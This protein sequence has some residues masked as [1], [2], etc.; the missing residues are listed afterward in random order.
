MRAKMTDLQRLSLDIYQG[1]NVV[2]NDVTGEQA[3]RNMITEAV[4]G[5]FNYK[6]FREN[7]YRVF[8]IIEEALDA[9]L[10]VV[11][12]NQFDSLAD[13][14]NVNAGD[15][16]SFRVEDNN[17]F[18]VARIAGGTNDLRRQKILN[19]HVTVDTDWYGVKIYE[20]LEM[21]IA[22]R[23]D[24]A[25]MVNR[26]ALSFSHFMGTKIYEA[27][28]NSYSALNS[29]RAVTG[30]YNEDALLDIVEHVEAKSGQKAS[31]FGTKKALRAISKGI[32]LS[33]SGKDQLNQ[34]GYVGTLAGTDLILLPQAHK[35]G[36]EEFFVDDK[37]LIIV[38][39]NEKIV[40][41]VIEG[42][43]LMIESADAGDRNDQQMEY[44]LQKKF[45][46]GVLQSSV[47]GIYKM[48]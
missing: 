47:Y 30:T 18:R 3:L 36:T 26:V 19:K 11:L 5:E 25:S 14:R 4:G 8:A 28:A 44:I 39:A 10:G 23:V 31:I 20:E 9:V 21:F 40:K 37:M 32:D 22:G 6:N 2:F 17:L 43:A 34:M 15:K 33:D 13:V 41:V 16:I 27:I 45:G 7:K 12:T 38:P 1:K 42:D 46:V 29:T 24:W 35:V 48:Q